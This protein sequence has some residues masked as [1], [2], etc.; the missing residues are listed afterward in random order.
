M[1]FDAQLAAA[2]QA[3]MAKGEGSLMQAALAA[4]RLSVAQADDG[5]N[6]HE[7]PK[8]SRT[9]KGRRHTGTRDKPLGFW[10]ADGTLR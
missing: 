6:E 1:K 7:A 8:R 3:D 4:I 2:L 9:G 5:A 10:K